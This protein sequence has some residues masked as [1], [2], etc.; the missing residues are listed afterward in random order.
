[1]KAERKKRAR[2][3]M[4]ALKDMFDFMY[5]GDKGTEELRRLLIGYGSPSAMIEA[6]MNR[7]K[8]E[9]MSEENAMLVA[10]LPD[11]VRHMEAVSHGKHPKI[12]SLLAA[13]KYLKHRYI[14]RNVENFHLL[15]LDKNGRLIECVHLHT[16]DED[17]V[18]FYLK[19]VMSEVVRTR[20]EA[21]VLCHNH[22]SGTIRPS[23]ADIECTRRL[24]RAV[25]HI[26]APLIDHVIMVGGHALSIRGFGFIQE[27]EWISQAPESRLMKG[28]L[29]GW[30]MEAAADTL[31]SISK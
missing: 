1:M 10:I 17:S 4:L 12:N 28:W 8:Y 18:P 23:G 25:A 15:S 5:P 31:K 27:S 19:S 14:G 16:G 7:L 30:D 13:E 29:A 2:E 26:G 9:G 24:L 3:S 11:I 22:P 20:A 6:G 21:I